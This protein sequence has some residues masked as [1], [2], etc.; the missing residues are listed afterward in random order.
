MARIRIIIAL[1]L[2]YA[3]FAILLNSVGTVILQSINS[4]GVAK[5][6]AAL[7]DGFKDIPIA[8]GSFLVASFLPRL[9]YRRAIMAGLVIV[10]LACAAMPLV[11]TFWMTR[12]LFVSVGVSFALVKISVYSSVGLIT[13]EQHRHASLISTI[14][15][16]F[17]A[18][19]LSGYWLFGLFIDPNA[20]SS[21]GWL[22]VY[23]VLSATSFAAAF[24]VLV[25]P[26]DESGAKP[27]KSR[28]ADDF[29]AFPRLMAEPFM[30]AYLAAT[31]LYVLVE[32]SFGTWLPTFNNKVLSL[33]P[34]MSVQAASIFAAAIMIGRFGG[35]AVLRKTSWIK[36]LIA[37][38]AG[39]AAVVLL[40]LPL[41]RSGG[42]APSNWADAPLAAY[43]VP[44]IGLFMG[45]IYP[46]VNSVILSALATERHSAMTGLIV[47]FSALGGTLGSFVTGRVFGW[48]GGQT[49][50][51]L[52]L[53]PMVLLA[54]S[55]IRLRTILGRTETALHQ[56]A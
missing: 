20:P 28:L 6:E 13:H 47:T 19:V 27:P 48:L 46:T 41:A 52:S 5:T 22:H 2:T 3:V 55:L 35:G 30:L 39:M 29:A 15:G 40:A 34:D 8:V 37:C 10:A 51:Y 25:S 11:E 7:L 14:E 31:F 33:P 36:V 16:V 45:P 23:W 24:L 12:L 38:I 53:V 54:L 1:C 56:P 49:A 26:L 21:L 43:L 42:P 32:Q 44:M 17:M 18:G 4:F 9:G 50:F